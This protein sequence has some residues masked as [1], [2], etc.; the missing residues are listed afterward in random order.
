MK[1][2]LFKTVLIIPMLMTAMFSAKAQSI[3]YTIRNDVQTSEKM[4]EFDLYLLNTNPQTPINL[5]ALQSSVFLNEEI[6]NGGTITASII[7]GTSEMNSNQQPT[8]ILYRNHCVMIAVRPHPNC[9]NGT[10]ISTTA[11]GTRLCRVRLSNTEAFASEKANM[12]FLFT[13]HPWR[14]VVMYFDSNCKKNEIQLDATNCFNLGNNPTL[15]TLGAVRTD[16]IRMISNTTAKA[17]GKITALG[18]PSPKEYGFVYSSINS[19]PSVSD[20]LVNRGGTSSIASF[21]DAITGLTAS[22]YYVRAFASSELGTVYGDVFTF[23]QN[24]KAKINFYQDPPKVFET[25]GSVII[26]LS[27]CGNN[28]FTAYLLD[29][30]GR[31]FWNKT[32][33]GGTVNTYTLPAKGGYVVKLNS[34]DFSKA[35]KIVF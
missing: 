17:C 3:N 10:I 20:S 22:S 5:C 4:L 7:P 21:T 23:N 6:E 24:K 19:Q 15:N 12:R 2:K 25:S 34:S 29:Q 14:T 11:S 16:S 31:V 26:D 30:I 8:A 35:Y 9:S 27:G 33:S 28:I 32:L 18:S 1:K 13:T